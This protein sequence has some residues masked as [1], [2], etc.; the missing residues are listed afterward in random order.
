[1]G[2]R[3]IS[4]RHHW[5]GELLRVHMFR[6]R[7]YWYHGRNREAAEMRLA[8][9]LI[10]PGSLVL[11]V[12]AN[13]GYLSLYYRSAHEN[14]AVIAIEPSPNN[15]RYL[16]TNTAASR[17]EVIAAAVGE[18][19]GEVTLH[20]DDLTG[21]NSSL[22]PGFGVLAAN[23]RSAGVSL[24][25]TTVQ[26][27]MTTIDDLLVSR[28][29]TVSFAKIDVE[30]SEL[31]VLQGA[32]Q[33]LRHARPHLQVEVQVDIGEVL[34]LLEELDYIVFSVWR[35]SSLVTSSS[36]TT[37]FALPVETR[38]FKVFEVHARDLGFTRL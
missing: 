38:H 5:T 18:S 34:S 14:V 3:D 17:I 15:L 37:V 24:R 28:S 19:S 7:G 32:R 9:L 4:V 6:H 11:D 36:P 12:G 16:R 13:I 21:Q 29:G 27:P 1:L 22:I 23:A 35:R 26:V 33:T 25:T 8:R 30:G 10:S 20:E 2:D 31:R